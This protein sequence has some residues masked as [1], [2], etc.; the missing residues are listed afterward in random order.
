M[1]ARNPAF[2]DRKRYALGARAG[3]TMSVSFTGG[4]DV[5]LRLLEDDNAEVTEAAHKINAVLKKN[6]DYTVEL[7]NYGDKPVTVTVTIRI[8]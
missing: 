7:S 3:Q 1:P 4:G 6:G 2:D 5:E 8:K